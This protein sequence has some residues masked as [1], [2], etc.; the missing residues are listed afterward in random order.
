VGGK[1][2]DDSGTQD[3]RPE[4]Y[5][6]VLLAE[7]ASLRQGNAEILHYLSQQGVRLDPA[8]VILTRLQVL[9]DLI[10]TSEHKIVYDHAFE[11]KMREQLEAARSQFNQQKLLAGVTG[12]GPAF[13][14]SSK[15]PGS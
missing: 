15:H 2:L 3:Q 8:G 1:I 7:T 11:V 14:F 4:D 10:L 6:A 12:A 9:V 13:G 5:L